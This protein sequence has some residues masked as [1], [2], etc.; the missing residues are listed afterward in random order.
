MSPMSRAFVFALLGL[1][2]ACDTVTPGSMVPLAPPQAWRAGLEAHRERKDQYFRQ[3]PDSP[4]VAADIAS[5]AGLPYW[6]PDARYYFVGPIH[7]YPDKSRFDIVT[8]AGNSR[9]CEKFGW[10]EFP[11]G[12][13][14]QRLEVYRLLDLDLGWTLEALLIPFEDGTTGTETY[15][16]G[17]YV[18]LEGPPGEIVVGPGPDGRLR[19]AGPYVLDFNRA[20]NPSCAYGAP[21]RFACPVTPRDNRMNVRIEAG[22]RGFR[23]PAGLA[24][25]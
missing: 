4:L 12:G 25:A 10:I 8:T 16:A 19:A 21:E 20:F 14:P 2:P 15:P 1:V 5:F 9:P 11:V 7:V 3:S 18:D 13:R 24:G 6:E 22:E 17:R 23:A